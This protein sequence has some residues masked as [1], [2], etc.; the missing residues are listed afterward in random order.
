MHIV[1]GVLG[2]SE[3]ARSLRVVRKNKDKKK[4]RKL[5]RN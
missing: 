3:R 5:Q 2:G 1:M 4:N